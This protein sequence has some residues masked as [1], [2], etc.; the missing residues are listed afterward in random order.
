MIDH[1]YYETLNADGSKTI[2]E[3]ANEAD[4]PSGVNVFPIYKSSPWLICRYSDDTGGKIT[5]VRREYMPY[6]KDLISTIPFTS[7]IYNTSDK[8]Y[9]VNFTR[10]YF[11]SPQFR[12]YDTEGK[13]G[14]TTDN[15]E[16][17]LN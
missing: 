14:V 5:N 12:V 1:Y 10:T 9:S 7:W 11:L 16:I 15:K 17:T 13:V 4:A 2:H 6:W 8:V 3:I